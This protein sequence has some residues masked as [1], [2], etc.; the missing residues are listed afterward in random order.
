M[1]RVILTGQ[2]TES[3]PLSPPLASRV[4]PPLCRL[5]PFRSFPP[6]PRRGQQRTVQ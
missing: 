1:I 3:S 6:P 5:R 4:R 2:L